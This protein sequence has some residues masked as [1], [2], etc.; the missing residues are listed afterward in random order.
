VKF[1]ELHASCIHSSRFL[2]ISLYKTLHTR[3]AIS[4]HTILQHDLTKTLMIQYTAHSTCI[5]ILRNASANA[6]THAQ[7]ITCHTAKRHSEKKGPL[8]EQKNVT[9]PNTPLCILHD[10]TVLPA[11]WSLTHISR[12]N[13]ERPPPM[14]IP[15]NITILAATVCIPHDITILTDIPF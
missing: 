7:S 13:T 15:H 5:Q 1:T 12:H 11:M 3:Y 4:K 8:T 9:L 6:Y 10:I 14:C 2:T